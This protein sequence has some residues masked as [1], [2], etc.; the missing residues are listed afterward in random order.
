MKKLLCVLPAALCLAA[1]CP[2]QRPAQPRTLSVSA[3][4]EIKVSPDRVA[5]TMG[6]S[7]RT[8]ELQEGREELAQA[9]QRVQNWLKEQQTDPNAFQLLRLSVTPVYRYEPSLSATD[10]PAQAGYDFTQTFTLTLKDPAEY[11]KILYGLLELGINR[12]DDVSF[13]SSEILKYRDEARLAALEA[14]QRKAALLAGGAGVELGEILSL[15]ESGGPV[16]YRAVSNAVQ[17]SADGAGAGEELGFISVK[18][19]VSLTR[20]IK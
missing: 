7:R 6:I 9:M 20:A 4:A 12:V 13:Y 1:C 18:A 14:A 3:E 19:S 11:Q 2:G 17:N 15:S 8:K 10:S 16:Y 5:L